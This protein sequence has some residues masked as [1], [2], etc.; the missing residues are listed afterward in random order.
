MSQR[1]QFRGCVWRDRY[2]WQHVQQNG[3]HT[4]QQCSV[5]RGRYVDR[6]ESGLCNCLNAVRQILWH[7]VGMHELHYDAQFMW[8]VCVRCDVFQL[9]VVIVRDRCHAP[10]NLNVV[11][12]TI[13]SFVEMEK[14]KT[15]QSTKVSHQ[16]HLAFMITI[17]WCDKHLQG[18]QSQHSWIQGAG[19]R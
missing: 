2:Q 8:G 4:F 6:F 18:T 5:W 14:F 7:V 10:V 19:S 13:M 11:H 17:D 12:G 3:R 1:V 16:E 9:C 15:K